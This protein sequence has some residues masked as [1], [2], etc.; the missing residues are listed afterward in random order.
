MRS[1]K[2]VQVGEV[3]ADVE[4]A[5]RNHRSNDGCSRQ[6][7]RRSRDHRLHL[8]RHGYAAVRRQLHR[9]IFSGRSALELYRLPALVHDRIPRPVRRVDRV[10]VG[11]YALLRSHLHPV[12][13]AVDD[14]R[15]SCGKN[16]DYR[17]SILLGMLL[18]FDFLNV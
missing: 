6:S 11:L 4:L 14:H 1:V 15:E 3:V 12:L 8:R 7:L 13:S 16:W 9:G 18:S 2:G 17:M 5:D 10:H